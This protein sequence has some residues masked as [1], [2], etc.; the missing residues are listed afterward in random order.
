ML[1]DLVATQY[2]FSREQCDDYAFLS[3][4]RA[5]AAKAD[6][7]FSRALTPIKNAEGAIVLEAGTIAP[8]SARDR[9]QTHG[10]RDD[11]ERQM[12][13]V[14]SPLEISQRISGA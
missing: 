11:E 4:S 7:R 1:A 3:H 8:R 10:A 2:G 6:G 5:A 13:H 12:A 9:H 14:P